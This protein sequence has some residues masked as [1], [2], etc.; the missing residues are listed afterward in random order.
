[1]QLDSPPCAF[2]DADLLGGQMRRIKRVAEVADN[3]LVA[4]QVQI[5]VIWQLI[6]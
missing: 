2:A 5:S 1:M 6:S 4:E 3:Y